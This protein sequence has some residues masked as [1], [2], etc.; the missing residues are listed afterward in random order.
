MAL[1]VSLL[2][3]IFVSIKEL[4]MYLNLHIVVICIGVSSMEWPPYIT[5]SLLSIRYNY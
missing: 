4:T 3:S 5:S 1:I 2:A